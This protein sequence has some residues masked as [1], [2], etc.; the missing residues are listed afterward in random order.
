MSDRV[1][2]G[3]KFSDPFL[4]ILGGA[5]AGAAG[6]AAVA[7]RSP[8]G[9]DQYLWGA[10]AGLFVVFLFRLAH[11]ARNRRWVTPT[12]DGFVV[13]D[14]RGA[15]AFADG[16]VTD[17]AFTATPRHVNGHAAGALHT[18][19][20][21][22]RHGESDDVLDFRYST[23]T[24][25]PDPL[26]P[27]LERVLAG[28]TGRAA[29]EVAAG[30]S[31]AGDGWE[32]DR[33]GLTVRGRS[34]ERVVPIAEVSAV[35]VADGTVSVWVGGE[36]VASV[37][38][39]AGSRNARVL[40]RLLDRG[41]ASRPP[42]PDDGE[43]LGRV[44]FERDR[45][46]SARVVVGVTL[47]VGAPLLALAAWGG[48][49]RAVGTVAAVYAVVAFPVFLAAWLTR[50]SV[51]RCH[52]RGVSHR[53]RRGVRELR[54][55]DVGEFTYSAVRRYYKCVYT[56]TRL[57]LSFAPRGGGRKLVY[58]ADVEHVDGELDGL[59]QHVARVIASHW[60]DRLRVGKSARWTEHVRFRQDGLEMTTTGGLFR[61]SKTWLLPYEDV[62]GTDIQA[63]A[64]FLFEHGRKKPV[65]HT[66]VDV[67]NFF[68]GL[69]LLDLILHPPAPVPA[70]RGA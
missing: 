62:A 59:R 42:E 58:S 35:G 64:F 66:P 68:P 33:T 18:G 60:L 29:A 43:G 2:V 31:V 21:V 3:T 61:R 10:A 46:T 50:T 7:A 45:S 25:R 56:G 6:L 20:L 28:L 54:Y 26:G 17:L 24:G 39:P 53:T 65:Y 4:Y 52:L 19:R 1:S 12:A 40:A 38:V 11:V 69:A 51:F 14:R 8:K 37:R 55:E 27:F 67:P 22:L 41:L 70:G 48:G 9:L 44:I 34:G 57:T 23:P 15:V 36:A 30:R 49:L 63:G 16:Q 13:E 47:G 5:A 32:L